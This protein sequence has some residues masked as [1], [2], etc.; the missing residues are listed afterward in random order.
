MPILLVFIVFAITFVQGPLQ[1]AGWLW[2]SGN[3]FG[4]LGF[5][6]MLYLFLDV[7]ASRRQRIHQLISYGVMASL[8]IHVA[9]LWI[10]DQTIWYYMTLDGPVYMMAG[11]IALLLLIAVTILALPATR[12]VWHLHHRQFKRWHYGCSIIAISAG[13]W[14]IAGSGFYFSQFESWLLL[15]VTLAVVGT[16]YFNLASRPEPHRLTLV[17]VPAMALAF[18][19]LKGFSF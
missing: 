6:G 12:R 1:A 15:A 17:A 10:P 14:H 13:F 18:V 16:R 9:W 2:D 4:I 11:S 19:L 8:L 7:G 3:A 5:A